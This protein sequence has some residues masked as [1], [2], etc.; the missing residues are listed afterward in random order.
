MSHFSDLN[1]AARFK[2]IVH[3][4]ASEVLSEM[5][6]RP[7]FGTVTA[8]ASDGLTAT[9]VYA[10][11]PIN[12]VLNVQLACP[13]G[14]GAIVRVVGPSGKRY[15]DL[16][17]NGSLSSPGRRNLFDNGAFNI[18]QRGLGVAGITGDGFYG[19]D[20]LRTNFAA[21]FG[22]WTT[23]TWPTGVNDLPGNG[24][25]FKNKPYFLNNIS[26]PTPAA[27]DYIYQEQNLDSQNLQHLLWGTPSAKPL[28]WSGWLYPSIAGTFYIQ[29]QFGPSSGTRFATVPLVLPANTWTF[30]TVTFPPNTFDVI[31][32][33]TALNVRLQLCVGAGSDYTSGVWS[34]AWTTNNANR[35]PGQ[36]NLASAINQYIVMA[37]WQ[38][39][40]GSVATPFEHRAPADVLRDCLPYFQRWR[41]PP[42][43]GVVAST[44]AP[45]RMAMALPVPMYFAPSITQTGTMNFFDGSATLAIAAAPAASYSTASSIELDWAATG[46]VPGRACVLYKYGSDYM[47][48]SA[49]I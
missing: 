39:E 27:T 6:P 1:I 19:P 7:R 42:L 46:L 48:F 20:R 10:D 41:Q 18:M 28:T 34:S 21:T 30:K 11:E 29:L 2:E 38:L 22:S 47:D 43:R 23:G 9:V 26:Y 33:T 24:F 12:P 5:I 17:V 16:V 44:G 3:N 4:V 13:V 40:V 15:I 37:G 32:D 36:T 8:V 31:P 14:V 25:Q 49:D 45:G 35:F